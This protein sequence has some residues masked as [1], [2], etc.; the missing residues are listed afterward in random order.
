MNSA[1]YYLEWGQD[2][3]VTPNGSIQMATGWDQ[4]RQRIERRL[5]TNPAETLPDGEPVEPDYLY[6]TSY[7]LGAG[8]L[9]GQPRT[10]QLLGQILQVVNAG[11]MV[12]DAVSNAAPP[13]VS[14]YVINPSETLLII[15][16]DLLTG[17]VGQIAIATTP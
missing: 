6:D 9:I 1:E 7:G 3:I 17:E 8:K 5:L 4:V 10:K 15:G 13:S 12:D 16:V 2:F 11:V 14:L